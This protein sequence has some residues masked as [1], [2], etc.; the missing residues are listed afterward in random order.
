[1]FLIRIYWKTKQQCHFR[2]GILI[3][4]IDLH[5]TNFRFCWP[6]IL[7]IFVMKTNLIHHL[8]LIYFLKKP[9]HVSGVFIAYHQEVFTVYVQQLVRVIR[10][11]WPG[12]SVGIPTGYGLDGP[13][14]ESRWGR[15]FPHLF[16]PA[17]EPTQPSVQWVPS[18]NRLRDAQSIRRNMVEEYYIQDHALIKKIYYFF[19]HSL[20]FF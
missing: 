16:R 9:L 19:E 20:V 4:C 3:T 15:V 11:G 2:I 10:L 17:L 12:S 13:G 7:I 18:N 6:W 5:N 8:S 14:I 1:M